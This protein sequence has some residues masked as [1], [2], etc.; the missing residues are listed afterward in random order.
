MIKCPSSVT[1]ENE[2]IS[3]LSF[4]LTRL[5]HMIITA[6]LQRLAEPSVLF[7]T[8][9]PSPRARHERGGLLL[10]CNVVGD[11]HVAIAPRKT[12]DFQDL[13]KGSS[14]KCTVRVKDKP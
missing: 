9:T 4:G 3:R 12:C 10:L 11:C 6:V 13:A 14:E 7:A 2:L 8:S 5:N 1:E